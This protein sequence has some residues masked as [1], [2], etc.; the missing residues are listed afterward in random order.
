MVLEQVGARDLLAVT[1]KCR[2]LLISAVQNS[3]PAIRQRAIGLALKLTGESLE[4]LA[5]LTND[6]DPGVRRAVVLALV[7][8]REW[9]SD[10]ELLPRLHD[11]EREIQRLARI[12]LRS[13]GLTEEQVHM[14]RLLTDPR[15]GARLDLVALLYHDAELDLRP[16]GCCGL[17]AMP[18]RRFAR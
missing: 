4:F 1:E 18:R 13:R 7:A 10:D 6:S 8:S 12:A 15:P 3:S 2:Q 17:A 9:L 16:H 5:P 11:P 14:G